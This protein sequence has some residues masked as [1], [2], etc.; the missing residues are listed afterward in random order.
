[1][2][3]LTYTAAGLA[4]LSVWLFWGDFA[5]YMK[6]RT[7]Q[8][9]VP[10]LL[11]QFHASDSV[12]GL[13]LVSI[14]AAIGLFL[15]PIFSYKSDRHRGKWGR[16]VPYLLIPTPIAAVAMI[17]FAFSPMLGAKLH[18]ALGARSWGF[19]SSVLFFLGVFWTVFECVSVVANA[20]FTAFVNDV[21]P[22]EMLGRFYGI[23]RALSLIA[24][25]VFNY[26]I[27]GNADKHYVAIFVSVGVL[28]VGGFMLMCLKV[29]EGKYPPPP[30]KEEGGRIF[31]A[32]AATGSYFRDC[33]T[34]PY[35]YWV[36]ASLVL[37]W[38]A[39]LPINTYNLFFSQ[40]V[41]MSQDV[42]GKLMALY[43]GLSLLQ[44]LPLGWL[45]DKF[46]PLRVAMVGLVLHGG[47]SLWGALFI[48]DAK[49]FGIAFVLTGAFSGTWFTA[50]AAMASLMLP[51]IKFAQY[52]SALGCIQSVAQMMTGWMIG[53]F[54]DHTGHQYHYTYMVGFLL[55]AASLMATVVVF[56]MFLKLGGMKGYVA[57]E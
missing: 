16:R 48:H 42:Y 27:F 46:H 7:V 15:V 5:W 51:K 54:L 47:A 32:L 57:P 12:T 11:K 8:Q 34:K 23:F 37:P 41:H 38:L 36:F 2:G 43:F 21:V 20:I 44:A 30:P 31:S 13:L 55:D 9:L 10:L 56:R 53:K 28:Y 22:R 4:A 17:C 1:V 19:D 35:Y 18:G 26:W 39:F 49:T 29:K 40:T 3:T 6:E 25:I 52:A 24:G 33:F 50:T 14:P 45:V